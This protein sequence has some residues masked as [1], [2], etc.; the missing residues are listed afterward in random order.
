MVIL[1][2]F[3]RPNVAEFSYELKGVNDRFKVICLHRTDIPLPD[4]PVGSNK[5]HYRSTPSQRGC[6]GKSKGNEKAI[7]NKRLDTIS[8]VISIELYLIS[9]KERSF[10]AKDLLSKKVGLFKKNLNS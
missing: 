2:I 3:G 8:D 9:F 5:P 4:I 1:I 7:N 10:C 6:F